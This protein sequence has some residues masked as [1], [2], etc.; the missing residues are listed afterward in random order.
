MSQKKYLEA[1]QSLVRSLDRLD[2]D[3]KG[4]DGLSEVKE[5]LFN[6]KETLYNRLLEDL[7]KQLF[8]ESTWDVLRNKQDQNPFQRS[9]SNQ[10]SRGSK[11]GPGTGSGRKKPDS[12]ISRPGSGM[13]PMSTV[14]P[15]L[16]SCLLTF[17]K[18][19]S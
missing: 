15:R 16:H 4:V 9:S 19:D 12:D 8:I 1:T 10:G 11:R 17:L 3:L 14:Q 6:Q 13:W 18:S 5:V 2:G 7:T